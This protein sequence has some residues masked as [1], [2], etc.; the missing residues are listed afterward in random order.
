MG[1]P[2]VAK[3]RGAGRPAQPIYTQE[4]LLLTIDNRSFNGIQQPAKKICGCFHPENRD[5]L[6]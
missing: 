1:L 6:G 3:S 5:D 2:D 4:D